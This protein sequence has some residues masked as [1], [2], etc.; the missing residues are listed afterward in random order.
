[1]KETLPLRHTTPPFTRQDVFAYLVPGATLVVLV[2]LFEFWCSTIFMKNHAESVR[3]PIYTAFN[4]TAMTDGN[5]AATLVYLLATLV[6]AYVLGHL[7]A[8][9]SVFFI[10]R[11]LIA[12]GHS[13]PWRQLLDFPE[14][15]AARIKIKRYSYPAL[16]VAVNVY[17]AAQFL[18]LFL[19]TGWWRQ[20]TSFL[21]W[22]ALG[23]LVFKFLVTPSLGHILPRLTVAIWKVFWF[24]YGV[25]TDYLGRNTRTTEPMKPAVID[26]FEQRFEK[27][28]GVCVEDAGNG[29]YWFPR[30]FVRE[31][32][33]RFDS[34]VVYYH[35]L[36]SFTRNL[37]TA[38]YLAFVYCWI[39]LTL[40]NGVAVADSSYNVILSAAVPGLMFL[41]SFALLSR[42][43]Y[44]YVSKH[45]RLLFRVFVYL[46]GE[47]KMK[48]DAKETPQAA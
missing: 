11:I 25:I 22:L 36:Y 12:K 1:M 20:L 23:L 6:F 48:V 43:Y 15:T 28:F 19:D 31:R 35:H 3:A 21:G 13:Y 37:A 5:W 30:I 26:A 38:F 34:M 47:G 18:A 7:V 9:V 2:Y 24:P 17:V 10:D 14:S 45:T 29:A 40:Q 16:F 4:S 8:W 32:S 39:S 27:S 41:A 33:A 46:S 42:F 44:V